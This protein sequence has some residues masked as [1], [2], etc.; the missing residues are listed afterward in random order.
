MGQVERF[1]RVEPKRVLLR[2]PAQTPLSATVTIVPE[3]GRSFR[4][5]DVTLRNANQVRSRLE[6]KTVDGQHQ[7]LLTID[8]VVEHPGRYYN[9]VV[10][11][12]DHPQQPEITIPV[13]GQIEGAETHK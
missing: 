13:Y 1:V 11:K 5:V 6:E 12:T 4:I 10:L 9:Q 8:N 7:Y 2:G 3:A